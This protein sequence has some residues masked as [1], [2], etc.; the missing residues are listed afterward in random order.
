[1]FFMSDV[2]FVPQGT[3][4]GTRKKRKGRGYGKYRTTLLALIQAKKQGT[5][6]EAVFPVK[7]NNHL[8]I[9]RNALWRAKER[10][11]LQELSTETREQ[12]DKQLLVVWLP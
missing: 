9:L 2:Q 5:P 6:Q 8:N 7:S 3:K 4:P 12:D 1:M 10:I 11:G